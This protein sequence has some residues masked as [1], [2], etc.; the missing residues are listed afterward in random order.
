MITCQLYQGQTFTVNT[1]STNVDNMTYSVLRSNTTANDKQRMAFIIPASQLDNIANGTITSTYFK[2][3]TASGSLNAG[4]NFRIYLKNTTATD[5]GSGSPDWD[6]ETVSATLVYDSNPQTAAGSTAGYKQFQHSANFVYTAGSNLAVYTEYVQT[7]AQASTIY[8]QYEYSSPCINTSNSNTTKYVSATAAFGATLSSSNYRRPVIAFDATVPPPTTPPA[9][10][11]ISAPANA[12][13]GVSVTPTITWAATPLTSSYVINM[14]TTPGGTDIMNGVDVGNVT[15]YVIPAATPL[16][17]LTQYYVTVM[18]KNV[19]GMA[20]GCTENTFTTLAMPCPSVSSPAAAATGVSTIPTISWGAVSGATGYR[21]TMGT[22]SG[23]TDVLNNIDLGNVTS[24]T[25]ASALTPSTMYYYTVTSYNASANSGT[26]T[27]RS[28]TTTATAPPANDNCGGAI[29]LTVNPDLACGAT[30][31]G[32]TLGASL[33]I[34]A[35]PCNGN[36]DDDVWYS[37]VATAASHIVALSNVVSTGTT[38]ASDMYFQVLSG[39][40]GSQT[41]VLCSDPNTA[42]VSGLTPGQTYYIRVYT[43]SGAGYNTSFNI[44]VGTPPPPPANDNCANPTPLTVGGTFGANAITATNVGSTADGTAQS[45]QTSATNNVW[46]SVVVPASGTLKVETNSVAGSTYTDSII[47]VFSGACGSLTAVACDDDSSADGN[48]SLVTLTG[49]T[50]G[51]TLLVSVWRYSSGAGTDGKFQISAYD[52]SLLATSEVSGAKNEL[53]AY[54]NPFAD[55]LNISDISKVKSVSIV[56]LAGRV[57]KTIDNP[58]SALQLGDLKQGMY[59]VTL[60][61]KDGSKQTI[62]AIKK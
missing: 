25:F 49:Q 3:A 6:T 48:F 35:T 18:P 38:S 27:V 19:V 30:T 4:A 20:T 46:Y 31:A 62:K 58:S 8:W 36:P 15:S 54:P 17:Y 59:L 10:T 40:C 12:A 52:A 42:T 33:S 24:Y 55:V 26:C 34:A 14:G 51:A 57:V 7:T 28:F 5:F 44:C 11:T 56:D 45:C 9:C 23:G 53:K 43:Y 50:P 32:N 2:R 60:N 13:T 37:F 39:V 21:L 16:S 61:M 29:G 22:T 1:C 47:N 41:S